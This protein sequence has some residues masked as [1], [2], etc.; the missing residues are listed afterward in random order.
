MMKGLASM[1]AALHEQLADALVRFTGTTRLYEL[2]VG[3]DASNDLLVE[4]FQCIDAIQ[5]VGARRVVALTTDAHI[6]MSALLGQPATLAISLADGRRTHFTGIVTEAALLSSDGGFA[7]YCLT[8]SPWLWRLEGVRHCRVWEN[9]SVSE[10]VDDVFRAYQPR[11]R[12]RWSSETPRFVA[13]AVPRSYC[14]Q[15]RETDFAFVQRLLTEEGLCWR[16]EHDDEGV[17]CVLFSNSTQVC[18]VRSVPPRMVASAM[19]TP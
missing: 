9:R 10:I 6:D 13:D 14:C 3:D 17:C 16:F 11:A 8:I 15:Y 1:S 12:W 19:A 18:A 7:R 4:A 2:T 5:D